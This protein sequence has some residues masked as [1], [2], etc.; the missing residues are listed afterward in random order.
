MEDRIWD[1]DVVLV[2]LDGSESSARALPVAWE[3]A[4]GL[5][6]QVLLLSVVAKEQ[7]LKHREKELAALD[8]PHGRAPRRTVVLDPDPAHAIHDALLLNR[9][10]VACMATH[11]RGRS[12]ALVGSVATEVVARGHDPLVLVGPLVGDRRGPAVGVVT[13]VDDTPASAALIPLAL[14]WARR[15]VQPLE[16]VTVAEPAPRSVRDGSFHR[17]FGPE[18]DVEAF[19]KELLARVSIDEGA[20]VSAVALYDPISPAEGVRSY[21]YRRDDPAALVVVSSRV[22]TG[23]SRLVFGS[24]AAAIVHHS[25]SAV[26]VVPRGTLGDPEIALR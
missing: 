6:A 18:G 11:G 25:P 14:G 21:L 4:R 5:D 10:A 9:P 15:L 19:L 12:A 24:V 13:C 2:P 26:M 1:I 17:R 20:A 22:R 23:V 7:D 8:L 16:V 3:L